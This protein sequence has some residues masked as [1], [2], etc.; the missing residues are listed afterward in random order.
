M[1]AGPPSDA[2]SDPLIAP[3]GRPLGVSFLLVSWGNVRVYGVHAGLPVCGGVEE[4]VMLDHNTR[5]R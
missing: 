3:W 1:Q 4:D 5:P 2:P